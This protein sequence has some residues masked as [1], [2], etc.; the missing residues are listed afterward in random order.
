MLVR[1]RVLRQRTIS[2]LKGANISGQE[3]CS[4]DDTLGAVDLVSTHSAGLPIISLLLLELHITLELGA[5]QGHGPA[6]LEE[7]IQSRDIPRSMLNIPLSH[8]TLWTSR[9][10]LGASLT[11]PVLCV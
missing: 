7:G 4:Y 9:S 5:S 8:S 3:D 2:A 10:A 11:R 6:R 1:V